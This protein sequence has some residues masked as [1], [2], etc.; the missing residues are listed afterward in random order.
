[1]ASKSLGTL[2]LDLIA[3]VGGYVGG[4]DKAERSSEKWRKQVEKDVKAV[5]TAFGVGVSAITVATGALIANQIDMAKEISRGAQLANASAEEFQ[6][7]AIAAETA[8]IS[9]EKL[10]DQLK[11]FNE[12]LGEFMQTGGGGMKDFFE[13]IAPL[14][15]ITTKEFQGL[16]GPQGLQL[17][18]DSLEKAGLSQQ[19]MSFYMEAMA[20]DTTALIPLLRNGGA[21][22]KLLGDEAQRA[23]AIMSDETITA[24]D[25][26]AASLFL[27]DQASTGL[28]NQ[29]GSGLLPVVADIATAFTDVSVNGS[30]ADAVAEGL[31]TTLKTIIAT[32]VG[33]AAAFDLVGKSLG[34]IASLAKTATQGGQGIAGILPHNLPATIARNWGAVKDQ[35]DIVGEDLGTTSKE[36]AELLDKIWNAG[37][38][39]KGN[40]ADGVESRIERIAKLLKEMREASTAANGTMATSSKDADKAAEK[41]LSSYQNIEDSLARQLAL[42]SE[43]TEMQKVRYEIEHGNLVGINEEQ[44]KKLE[45]MAQE[46][47]AIEQAKQME[48]ERNDLAKEYESVRES[49]LSQEEQLKEQAQER[50]DVLEKAFEA[51][52][53]GEREFGELMIQNSERLKEEIDGIKKKTEELDEFTKNAARS[54][55]SELSD[56]II[57]GLEGSSDDLLK[58][59]GKLLERMVADALAADLTRA[60]FGQ[61]NGSGQMGVGE[62]FSGIAGIFGGFFDSGGNIGYG[63]W[64]IVGEKG[65][66]IVQ[67]PAVVT[68]R[69]ETQKALSGNSIGNINMNFPGVTNAQE[70]RRAAG[71]AGRELLGIIQ[72]SQRYA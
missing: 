49:L 20:S 36:Y 48:Q 15:N 24:A 57:G 5:G 67:G 58:R 55:Q 2:T 31:G 52:I 62:L 51:G 23:G 47:D 19:E 26:L 21:G 50:A 65:P 18:Y 40:T 42:N 72:G 63:Q 25:T 71:A 60:L 33:V 44:Q 9:Q 27:V 30:A 56:A 16:S 32:A 34:G 38:Q 14:V 6:R 43:S 61:T 41:L 7:Y 39:D 17:Y 12:K 28:K 8:G 13:N 1:M 3:K 64:G 70:A 45:I 46:I 29:I 53:I 37:D 54:I 68:G 22:F 66:E 69:M 11:D 59:W 10:S 4:M 35:L